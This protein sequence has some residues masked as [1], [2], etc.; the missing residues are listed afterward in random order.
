MIQLP[1]INY[2]WQLVPRK[3]IETLFIAVH[4]GQLCIVNCQ[5]SLHSPWS[6]SMYIRADSIRAEIELGCPSMVGRLRA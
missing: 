5:L 4:N 3:I 2:S 6:E 1:M